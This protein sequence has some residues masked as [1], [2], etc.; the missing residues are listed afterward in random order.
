LD[1][2][3]LGDVKHGQFMTG[4]VQTAGHRIAHHPQA[5][6]A[7]SLLDGIHLNIHFGKH[8]L[9]HPK[10]INGRGYAAINGD[11]QAIY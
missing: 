4:L 1:N 3:C 5:N 2:L 9:R 10:T 8:F 7:K 6:K 11:L